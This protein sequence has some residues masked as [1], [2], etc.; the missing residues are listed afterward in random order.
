MS[1][2]YFVHE[3]DEQYV[4]TFR[5]EAE[6]ERAAIHNLVE[7]INRWPN[8]QTYI[9]ARIQLN[10]QRT[11]IEAEWPVRTYYSRQQGLLYDEHNLFL[12]AW[13]WEKVTPQII[14]E[15]ATTNGTFI[16]FERH[17]IQ[18]SEAWQV[19]EAQRQKEV[20]RWEREQYWD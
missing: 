9:V 20:K 15:V 7:Q 13:Q 2:R 3:P 17:A 10:P 5:S 19:P 4:G 18:S 16:D 8:A 12:N 11:G 6:G 14:T 1:L